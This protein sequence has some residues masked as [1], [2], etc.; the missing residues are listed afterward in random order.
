MA[1]E[2]AL[3]HHEKWDGNG[4]PFQIE[5]TMIPLSARIVAIADVYDALRMKRSY[6]EAYTHDVA[7]QKILESK[8]SHF[9]PAL[10]D[11]FLAIADKFNEIFET[12]KD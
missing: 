1:K 7:V 2:I 10:T 4:Y 8:N 11:I 5:G 12:H 6:K 9:D 3:S